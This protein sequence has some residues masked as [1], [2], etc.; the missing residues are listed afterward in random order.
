M[1]LK[2]EDMQLFPMGLAIK[3]SDETDSLLPYEKLS[4]LTSTSE[5]RNIIQE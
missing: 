2:I 4:F 1:S 3:W 5:H